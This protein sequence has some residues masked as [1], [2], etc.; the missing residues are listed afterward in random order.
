MSDIF[1]TIGRE[2]GSGGREVGK[3]IAD[4]LGIRYYDSEIIAATA[5]E[6]G[7][8]EDAVT[9]EEERINDS[10][11]S[12]WGVTVPD[13]V[14]DAQSRAIRKMAEAGSAVFVGRC[15]DYV[16]RDRK[17]VVK[18]FIHAPMA[19]RIVRSSKRNGISAEAAAKRVVEKDRERAMYYQRY[20][21]QIWGAVK[22]YHLSVDTGPVGVDNAAELIIQYIRMS[23]NLR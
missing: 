23:G 10:R 19:D 8:S 18:V 3:R 7:Q 9:R 17:D 13:P 1:V 21:G 11:I 22:G 4:S 5:K 6:I 14:F 12:F 16:L 20:T 2:S 15:A